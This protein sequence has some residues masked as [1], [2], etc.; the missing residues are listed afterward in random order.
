M[1]EIAAAER[2]ARIRELFPVVRQIARRVSSMARGADPDDLVGDGSIGLIR[3]VDTFDETRGTSLEAYARKLIAGAMLNGLRR[4]DPVSERVRRTIRRAELRRY[5]IAQERGT[6]PTLAEMERSDAALRRAR[7]AAYRQGALSLDAP[8]PHGADGLS[9]RSLEP[10][11]QA[12][13]RLKG[14]RLREAIELLPLRQ[15]RI[16][17]LHYVKEESLH[18]IGVRLRV[19]PQRVSQLHLS[20]IS[21]LRK[22]LPQP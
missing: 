11:A 4:L 2:E 8:L 1:N 14:A 22:S 6:L 12:L 15:Q 17:A 3:A 19:S 20:A 16:I 7:V 18:A 13:E 5:A 9:D 21:H 10:S